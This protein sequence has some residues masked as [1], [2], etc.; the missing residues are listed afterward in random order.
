MG[1]ETLGDGF[2][3]GILDKL[4]RSD[5]CWELV[6]GLV[7]REEGHEKVSLEGEGM[8]IGRV[9]GG[10]GTG[11]GCGEGHLEGLDL[12]TMSGIAEGSCVG[13]DVAG[14]GREGE[15]SEANTTQ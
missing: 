5:G 14:D 9:P 7:E 13:Q 15:V 4:V 2:Q 11:K 12:G 10:Q 3:G 1:I 8:E 6:K